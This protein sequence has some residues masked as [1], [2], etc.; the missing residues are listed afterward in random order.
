MDQ[1]TGVTA[2]LTT[3]SWSFQESVSFR[4]LLRHLTLSTNTDGQP[5]TARP[6]MPN[7]DGLSSQLLAHNPE[8]S[9]NTIKNWRGMAT[10]YDKLAISF[11]AVVV[12]AAIWH[13]MRE[14]R[15]KPYPASTQIVRPATKT[16]TTASRIVSVVRR[17]GASDV[18]MR[19][20]RAI[21][22]RGNVTLIAMA[23]PPA[24]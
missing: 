3:E 1:P 17:R 15:S 18:P 7:V 12:L 23:N 24:M 10:R 2:P 13:R 21:R 5:F 19:N 20:S 4:P 22:N 14:G 6:G 11:R 16:A 8:R 9:F